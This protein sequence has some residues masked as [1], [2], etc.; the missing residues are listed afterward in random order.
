MSAEQ[1]TTISCEKKVGDGEI[2][3]QKGKDENENEDEEDE[4]EDVEDEA[5]RGSYLGT[6]EHWQKQYRI[7]L[8]TFLANNEDTGYNWFGERTLRSLLRFIQRMVP[9]SERPKVLDVGCGNGLLSIRLALSGYSDV[10]GAD[11]VDESVALA[12]KIAHHIISL[13]KTPA[14]IPTFTQDDIGSSHFPPNTFD[15]IVDKGCF[16]A[17]RYNPDGSGTSI[18]YA[19]SIATLLKSTGKFIITTCNST[20]EELRNEFAPILHYHSQSNE[21]PAF[22]FGGVTGHNASIVCF[23]LPPSPTI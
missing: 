11:Y 8:D 12:T 10:T 3:D 4:D 1:E 13:S 15:L 19:T 7:E 22:S 6:I 18:R 23:T 9:S 20:A 2:L 16:D 14:T 5:R 17:F 21:A